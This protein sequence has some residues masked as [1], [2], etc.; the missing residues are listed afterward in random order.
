MGVVV[1]ALVLGACAGS[2]DGTASDGSTP[3]TAPAE[4]P[5]HTATTAPASCIEQLPVERLVRLV[6][7]VLVPPG[8]D[9][10]GLVDRVGGIGLAGRP[11]EASVA[12]MR[13]AIDAAALPPLFASDEE[14]GTVQRLAG[15][16]G[17]L[18]S[19][20][21]IASMP[22]PQAKSTYDAYAAAMAELGLDL[23]FAPALDVGGEALGSR[24][25]SDDPDV[26][27]ER[28]GLFIDAM[29]DAGVLPVLKHFPGLGDGASNT[30]F[31]AA[32]TAPLPDLERRDLLPYRRLLGRS[33]VALMMSHAVVP[34]LT[35][36]MPS[37][38]SPAAYRYVADTFG[39]AGLTVTDTLGA[40]A[41]ATR[42][43]VPDAAVLAV[44]AGADM[45]LF[46]DAGELGGVLDAVTAAVTDGRIST[47]R[48]HAAASAV[49]TV[50]GVDPCALVGRL[51]T[52]SP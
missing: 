23:D 4:T 20:A 2:S 25:Y 39:F 22:L 12:A 28:A 48:L 10:A 24:S 9:V 49:L 7:F 43:S 3:A 51:D 37:S 14:G 40:G 34:G 35:D 47:A 6:P 32:E 46:T 33:P 8:G 41:I 19:A 1:V 27:V 15:V 42:W 26:V 13:T 45:V 21:R 17:A 30:D 44:A 36:G 29:T 50:Q 5:G 38:L 16:L 11:T 18:P 31:G 52:G